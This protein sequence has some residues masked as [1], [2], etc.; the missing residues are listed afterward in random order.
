MQV[1]LWSMAKSPLMFGGDLRK[2]DETTFG[3][4]TN[5]VILEI[6]SHST[7]NMEVLCQVHF[8]ILCL[9][10]SVCSCYLKWKLAQNI[11]LCFFCF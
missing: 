11:T 5:S 1:T 4:I 3:L 6:N 9:L 2:I 10:P 7:N 8:V